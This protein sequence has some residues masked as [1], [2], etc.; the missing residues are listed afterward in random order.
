MGPL[1]DLEEH[2]MTKKD[3]AE[4]F[5]GFDIIHSYTRQQAIEDG[6]LVDVT[7]TA[8]EAGFCYPVALTATVF[9]T[10]VEAPAS[11]PGQ[12]AAGRLWDILWMLRHAIRGSS[13]GGSEL[14]FQLHV[15]NSESAPPRL[16][17]L[18]SVCGPG[19]DGEPVITIMLPDE[20]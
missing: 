15:Q 8:H 2:K 1:D 18:K 19:D 16:V 5:E 13:G 4:L 9:G 3:D 10:Y 6:V 7:E 11:V 17:T 14:R 20:D 12:D